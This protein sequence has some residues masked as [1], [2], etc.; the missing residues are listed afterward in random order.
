MISGKFGVDKIIQS[1]LYQD[2]YYKMLSRQR[3][4]HTIQEDKMLM[5]IIALKK[6]SRLKNQITEDK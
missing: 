4:S 6:I 5:K 3:C 1:R 2:T